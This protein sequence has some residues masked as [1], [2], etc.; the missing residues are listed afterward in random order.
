MSHQNEA[1]TC[2]L[3]SKCVGRGVLSFPFT[4]RKP[5]FVPCWICTLTML[6]K[7]PANMCCSVVFLNA[8]H[9]LW[10]I[11]QCR[12]RP[13]CH[14]NAGS[15]WQDVRAKR[16]SLRASQKSNLEKLPE[17]IST[18]TADELEDYCT[19][20]ITQASQRFC[21]FVLIFA[22]RPKFIAERKA[23]S[24]WAFERFAMLRHTCLLHLM[25]R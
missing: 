3:L 1:L 2:K 11:E 6:T 19:C 22:S 24:S 4:L 8:F 23:V 20:P 16:P 18:M 15:D 12:I 5:T 10:G 7:T 14:S 21:H 9:K 17:A 25:C 13:K